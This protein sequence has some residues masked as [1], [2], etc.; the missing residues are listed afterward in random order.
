MWQLVRILAPLVALVMLLP[1][2]GVAAAQQDPP[3]TTPT[4][5]A[6]PP[7]DPAP[8]VGTVATVDLPAEPQTITIVVPA[9]PER[10]PKRAADRKQ[11]APPVRK[12]RSRATPTVSREVAESSQSSPRIVA[13]AEPDKPAKV[14]KAATTRRRRK[15]A[16][17][18]RPAA[19][20]VSRQAM[21]RVP[22]RM[23]AS[24]VLAAQ[25]S[26]ASVDPPAPASN[27]ILYLALA[28]AALLSMLVALVAAAPSLALLWPRV[29][30]RVI[31]VQEQLLLV[32]ACVVCG[33]ITLVLTWALTGPGA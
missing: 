3:A 11:A 10:A 17:P 28:F 8:P 1:G 4:E 14:A 6:P 20:R 5:T 18:T 12:N 16:R 9:L 19:P 13:A 22:D 21:I 2:L 23:P 7:E 24:G 29:F 30:A 25:F 26:S 33:A 32:A 15:P 27:T 31:P